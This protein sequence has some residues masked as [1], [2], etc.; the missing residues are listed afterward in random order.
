MFCILGIILFVH[1]NAASG[2]AHGLRI[3]MVT[4]L[5]LLIVRGSF[6]SCSADPEIAVR[7]P[8]AVFFL[9]LETLDKR[10]V[11]VPGGLEWDQFTALADTVFFSQTE[12]L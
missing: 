2:S 5:S 7:N 8:G 9:Y 6:S 4:K 12:S 1:I 3:F 10:T 11:C